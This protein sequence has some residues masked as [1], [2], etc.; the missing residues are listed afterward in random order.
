[1]ED[2]FRLSKLFE[3]AIKEPHLIIPGTIAL[4]NGY[5]HKIKFFL[6]CK[7]VTIGKGFRVYGNFHIMGTGR[8]IIGDNCFIQSKVFKTVSF[9]ALPAAV[10]EIG[11]SVGFNGTTIQCFQNIFIGD[12]CNIADAYIVDSP[13]HFLSADR[14]SFISQEIPTAPVR[15]EKNIWISTKVVICHGVTI[16][17]NS[18]VGACSLVR[19]DIPSDKFYAG[20]PLRFIKPIPSQHIPN[21]ERKNS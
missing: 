9:T 12:N 21:A 14:R 5:L 11:N 15:L 6:L 4:L 19:S 3:R 7:K 16:G 2:I 13:A 1:M 8:V 18:V 17:A 20:N 10:I